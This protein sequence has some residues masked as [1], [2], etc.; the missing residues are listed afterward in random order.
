MTLEEFFRRGLAAEKAV[1]KVM[2]SAAL[3]RKQK[4]LAKKHGTPAEFARACYGC[5]PGDISMDE[6]RAAVEKYNREWEAAA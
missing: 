4:R 5:V 1:R 2:A 3:S 6:A